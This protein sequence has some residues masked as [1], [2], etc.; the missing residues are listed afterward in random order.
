MRSKTIVKSTNR[1]DSGNPVTKSMANTG[2]Y[3]VSSIDKHAIMAENNNM[4]SSFMDS[5]SCKI[6][7]DVVD[8]PVQCQNNEHYF[9]RKCITKH[10]ENSQTCPM[11]MEQLTLETLRPVPRV[12]LEIISQL[13]K[14]RCSHVSR[15]CRED[16]CAEELLLHEQTCGYAPVVCANEGCKQTVNRRDKESHETKE[17]KFRKI[18]CEDCNEEMMYVDYEKHQCTLR[19][20]INEVKASL[21]E[22]NETMNKIVLAQG[23]MLKNHKAHEQRINDLENPL[24]SLNSTIIKRGH[25]VVIGK[26]F[27]FSGKSFEIFDWSTKKWTSVKNSLF[28]G[29]Q[30][31]F[32]F[33]YGK[34]MMIC[35]SKRIEFLNPSEN[36]FFSSVY[37]GNLPQT[38]YLNGVLCENRVISFDWHMYETSLE[39]PW[40]STVLMQGDIPK[41]NRSSAQENRAFCALECFGNDIFI[42]GFKGNQVERYNVAKNEITTLSTLPYEVYKMTTVAYKDNV[43][44]LGGQNREINSWSLDF[45]PLNDVMM[46]NIHTLE[47]K[48][49]PSMLEKRS[50]CSAVIMGDVIVVMGG[51]TSILNNIKTVEHYVMGD[52]T[53]KKLPDMNYSRVHGTACVYV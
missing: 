34:R 27:V 53:W 48:R 37:P 18:T 6:C 31:L 11:C 50:A 52:T 5:L 43:I 29:G 9:C 8:D 17:C 49:L 30:N 26:I 13:K 25:T 20:E 24:R 51:M 45:K 47:C 1:F 3:T 28:F 39:R 41:S 12:I 46:Y 21:K 22:I 10:L 32:S 23:E 35:G 16:V 44:I 38:D 40:K 19:K 42:I 15:G 4:N 36:G 14:P 7:L 33:L 2:A